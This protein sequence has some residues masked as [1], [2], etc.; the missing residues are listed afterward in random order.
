MG[1]AGGDF[2][3]AGRERL[4]VF[5]KGI[6]SHNDYLEFQF[7]LI[8]GDSDQTVRKRLI[9][10]RGRDDDQQWKGIRHLNQDALFQIDHAV[11]T[12]LG[13]KAG[14]R[15]TAGLMKQW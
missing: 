6:V 13:H 1:A 9:S 2:S 10:A 7:R 14:V 15:K 8:S 3:A 5:L 11:S 12:I 4:E